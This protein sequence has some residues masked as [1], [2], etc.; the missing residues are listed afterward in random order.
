MKKHKLSGIVTTVILLLTSLA[1]MAQPVITQQ[2]ANQTVLEGTTATFNIIATSSAPISYQWYKNGAEIGGA[3]LDSYT[4]PAT[5]LSDNGSNFSCVVQDSNGIR[6]SNTATLTVNAGEGPSITQHPEGQ[7]IL[8]GSTATFTVVATGTPT[9]Q[10]QW[11][12]NGVNIS[13]A[14]NSS[15]TTPAAILSDNSSVFNC[16]VTNNYGTETS[17]DATLYVIDQSTRISN[18][19]QVLYE[20]EDQ[21]GGIIHDVSGNGAAEDLTAITPNRIAWT[22]TGM[23]AFD[24]AIVRRSVQGS[25]IVQNCNTTNEITLEV[26]IQPEWIYQNSGRILTSSISDVDGNFTILPK[27]DHYEFLLHTTKTNGNGEPAIASTSGTQKLELTHIVYTKGTDGVAKVYINGELNSTGVVQGVIEFT[28]IYWLGV[29]SAPYGGAHWRG[30][31]YLAA[32]YNR[33]LTEFEVQHN[34]SVGTPVDTKP[35]F[36]IQPTDQNIIE[37]ESLFMDSYA[38]STWPITYRWKKNGVF[39]DGQNDRFLNL[40]NLTM[41]DD[42]AIFASTASSEG[43]HTIS[44]EARVHITSADGRVTRG[45]QALYNFREG[46]G[47][48]VNDVSGV[49]SKIDLTI[50]STEAVEWNNHGLRIKSEP[51]ISTTSPAQKIIDACKTSDEITLEAWLLPLNNTQTGPANIF[52]LSQDASH[53]NFTIGQTAGS[54]DVRLR[55]S[56]TDHNGLPSVSSNG[57]S[58]DDFNHVV[59]TRDENGNAKLYIDGTLRNSSTVSG[60]FDEWQ[61]YF[62]SMGAEVGGGSPWLG[63]LNLIAVFDRALSNSEVLRNYEYGA[64]GVVKTPTNL[65]V[66]E[67]K[68]GK[69]TLNWEDNSLNEN[70]FKIERASGDPL[71]FSEVGT[72]ETDITSF[73]DS[74]VVDNQVYHYR[75]KAYYNLG[76]SIYSN[77]VTIQSLITPLAVPTNLQYSYTLDGYPKITWDDNSSTE[78]GF[79]IERRLSISGSNF[80]VIDS[81]TSDV[82]EYIDLS[83]NDSTS[84]IYRLYAFNAD[85]V[86]EIS[87]QLFVEVITITDVKQEI[88]IPN[89]YSLSQNYP[90]PFNPSTKIKFSLPEKSNVNISIFNMLGQKVGE[91]LNGDFAAGYYEHNFNASNFPSGIYLYSIVATSTDGKSFKNTKKM[92]LI[93]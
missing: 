85:T 54:Y 16:V 83:V 10:Y 30:M 87:G 73:V 46:S 40:S 82:G 28:N 52:S 91:L 27:G 78:D 20:F 13:G 5:T 65:V 29:A 24:E 93:K 36:T 62:L 64:Y 22:P 44:N 23:E 66:V 47:N 21:E 11:K 84:Y 42:G 9:L 3:I 70:G 89:D 50:F 56:T 14:I 86:S 1:T 63:T 12:K 49:G 75:I 41:Q 58:S 19:L 26:W 69:I 60:N 76:E 67:N 48:K 37:G 4:T 35:A 71:T 15:Y 2:P 59:Y 90:N 80:A 77:E 79:K 53:R 7:T 88:E 38:V 39:I 45:V 33:A 74:N 31:Y 61:D 8:T 25:K 32:V 17:N 92:I 6:L 81:V 18:G 34:Y 68:I 72:V 43:G 57:V 55:T 51:S